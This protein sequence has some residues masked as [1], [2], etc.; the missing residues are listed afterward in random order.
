MGLLFL[1]RS[2]NKVFGAF[3]ASQLR[4]RWE[5][6]LDKLQ[7]PLATQIFQSPSH[8]LALWANFPLIV[9]TLWA[10]IPLIVVQARYLWA[11]LSLA[12]FCSL[13]LI[14]AYSDSPWLYE[15]LDQDWCSLKLQGY[16]T[17]TIYEPRLKFILLMSILSMKTA[18]HIIKTDAH[19]CDTSIDEY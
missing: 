14:L 18:I 3:V 16:D 1:G 4:S 7:G 8:C 15:C 2:P 10:N 9:V 11:K 17:N 13:L 5:A 19:I 12:L 6:G